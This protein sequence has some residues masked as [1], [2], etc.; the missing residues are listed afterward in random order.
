[1]KKNIILMIF[2]I[3]FLVKIDDGFSTSKEVAVLNCTSPSCYNSELYQFFKYH[4]YHSP[5]SFL[6]EDGS[7]M[8]PQF[9]YAYFFQQNEIKYVTIWWSPFTWHKDIMGK[10]NSRKKIKYQYLK[11]EDYN[12]VI[13]MD[14]EFQDQDLLTPCSSCLLDIK[15]LP[16]HV[17]MFYDGSSYPKTYKYYKDNNRYKFERQEQYNIDF[18]GK[19]RVE[20]ENFQLQRGLD[21]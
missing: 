5:R 15:L 19:E 12:F 13:I 10:A 8:Y 2:I 17:D 9:Y 4:I 20:W 16:K 1:M 6:K 11:V 18:L 7:P 3:L 21:K 14:K